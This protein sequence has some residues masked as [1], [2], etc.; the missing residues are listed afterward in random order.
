MSLLGKANPAAMETLRKAM[1]EE[2]P[3][4]GI[5][6][7]TV[8]RRKDE[9]PQTLIPQPQDPGFIQESGLVQDPG[10]MN[11]VTFKLLMVPGLPKPDT[12]FS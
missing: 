10:L 6:S 12:F 4:P 3:I 9:G 1:H 5:I 2:G 8:A 7:L 11:K